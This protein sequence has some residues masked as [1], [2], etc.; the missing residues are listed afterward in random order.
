MD[1]LLAYEFC[2]IGLCRWKNN[3]NLPLG[4]IYTFFSYVEQFSSDTSQLRRIH[5]FVVTTHSWVLVQCLLINV[6]FGLRYQSISWATAW[7]QLSMLLGDL[8]QSN[9][10]GPLAP[11][12]TPVTSINW[13][14]VPG[15]NSKLLMVI[16][17]CRRSSTSLTGHWS[18][19]VVVL[20]SNQTILGIACE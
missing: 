17:L 7:Q 19:L 16:L 13:A 10:N 11:T 20:L 2:A 8:I 14:S 15:C 3:A 12:C 6:F 18:T 4:S 5:M 1:T 9:S